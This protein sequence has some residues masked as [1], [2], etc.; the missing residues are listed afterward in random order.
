MLQRTFV[1]Y[2]GA[3]FRPNGRAV[4][5]YQLSA[6]EEHVQKTVKCACGR[7]RSEAES[8]SQ[9][10]NFSS[11]CIVRLCGYTHLIRNHVISI[12]FTEID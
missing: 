5:T 8:Q 10:S 4:A 3:I 6:S 11:A 2:S 9:S 1:Q 7:K 12:L